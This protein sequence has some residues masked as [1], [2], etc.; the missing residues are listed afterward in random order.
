M[1]YP[2][3]PVVSPNGG[4]VGLSEITAIGNNRYL[5][6]ERDNHMGPDARI[7]RIYRIDM[8]GK[9]D[10]AVLTKTLVRDLMNDLRGP[11]GLVLEKVEGLAV[12]PNGQVLIV[13]DNDGVNDHGGG[14]ETQLIRLGKL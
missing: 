4:W 8:T 6:V 11:K 2:I 12:L 3:E 13:T 7:K 14:G 5:V 1:S 10:G 9:A